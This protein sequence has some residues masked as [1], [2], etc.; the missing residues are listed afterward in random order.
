MDHYCE[1][2]DKYIKP[3]SEYK[4]F[5]SK[6]HK[7]F[8]KCE[9][10][11]SS[12]KGIDIIKIDQ[13]FH[14][15]IIEHSKKVDYYLVKCQFK[16]VF[17]DYQ[18]RPYVTSKLSDNK[19]MISSSNCLEKVIDDFKNK[20]YTF[21]HTAELHIIT[22]AKKLH[23]QYD[24]YVKQNMHAVEKEKNALTNENKSLIK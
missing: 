14:L 7:E 10:K 19:T 2:C 8:D 6:I 15:Y 16:L 5:K 12:L 23:I 3:K 24:F 1:V 21:N 4:H 9:H 20:G 22:I 13:P 18:F 11:I 17:K